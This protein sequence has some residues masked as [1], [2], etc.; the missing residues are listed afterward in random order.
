MKTK[1]LLILVLLS[2]FLLKAQ[3]INPQITEF[4]GFYDNDNVS[5]MERVSEEII[6]IAPDNYVG[7]AFVAYTSAVKNDLV[8][9]EKYM[10][11]ARNLN[12]VDG[13]SY[14]ISSYIQFLKGNT[15]E[16]EKL[17]EFSFQIKGSDQALTATLDD[18]NLI[19]RISGKDMTALKEITKTADAKYNQSPA[20]MQQ[21]YECFQYWS[22]GKLCDLSRVNSYF[23]GLQPTNNMVM[24]ITDYYKAINYYGAQNWTEAKEAFYTYL[25]NPIVINTVDVAYSKAQSY[26]Y[27]TE[28]NNSDLDYNGML[29]SANKGLKA[30]EEI[31]FP[32]NL[33]CQLLHKKVLALARLGKQDEELIIARQ[34]L[35]DANKLEFLL[36][37]AQANNTIGG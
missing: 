35:E 28:Y 5:E 20:M 14:G 29:N 25:N 24:A 16:A 7:Y 10:K 32:T 8:T 4:L 26:Y 37:Q 17:M 9:A 11:A 12:P 15:S 33:K 13:A 34:L 1:T 27:L 36:M 23:S 30:L 21:Y 3:D 19:E 22:Q 6:K 31:E 2:T 18:I